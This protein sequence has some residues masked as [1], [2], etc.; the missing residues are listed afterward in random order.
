MAVTFVCL[1]LD[2]TAFDPSPFESARHRCLAGGITVTTM[3]TLGDTDEARRALY[4]LNKVCSA[5]IPERGTFYS[6]DEYVAKRLSPPRYSPHGVL[7]ALDGDRWVGLAT[8]SLR[9]LTGDA[10]SDMTGVVAEHR[11]RGIALTMKLGAID[12]VRAQ[13]VRW[14]RTHHHPDNTAAIALNRSLGYTDIVAE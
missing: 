10:F 7:L 9:P 4:A 12:Y 14:L 2:V 6:W 8:T 5:D 1:E 11:G 3:A 13:G